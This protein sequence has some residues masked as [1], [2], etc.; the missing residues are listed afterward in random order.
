[1]LRENEGLHLSKDQKVKFNHLLG[2]F[3]NIFQPGGEPTPLV[4]HY[5]KTREH[6]PISV[7]PYRLSPSKKELLKTQIDDL[8]AKG[9]IEECESPYS[10]PVVLIPNPNGSVRLCDDY[11]KLNSVTIPNAYPFPRLDD[12]LHQAKPPSLYQL[13]I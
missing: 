6:L 11:R 7:P 5:I 3:S 8:L 1:M 2:K 13:F 10:A 4:K 9:I 12:L